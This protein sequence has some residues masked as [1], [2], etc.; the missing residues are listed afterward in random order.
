M[1]SPRFQQGDDRQEQE[2]GAGA[3]ASL[4]LTWSGAVPVSECGLG[5]WF[6]RRL[7]AA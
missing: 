2:A 7:G 1:F 4:L 3:S 6:A 5:P